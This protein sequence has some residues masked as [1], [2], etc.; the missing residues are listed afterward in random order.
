MSIADSLSRTGYT[1][2]KEG[3]TKIIEYDLPAK[4]KAL[5]KAL[6][7]KP[8]PNVLEKVADVSTVSSKRTADSSESSERSYSDVEMADGQDH[9]SSDAS[10]HADTQLPRAANGMMKT[11]R[12]RGERVIAA[13]EC[14][15]H[16][17]RLFRN[18]RIMCSYLF[19]RHGA[20]APLTKEKL[21]VVTADI[22]F[23]DLI[24]V[25]PTRFRPAAKMGE[26]LFEH[27]QNELLAK[28]ISTS[29]RLRD[30]NY[31]LAAIS[32]KN[33][34]SDDAARRQ[35]FGKVLDALIQVQIDVNSFM[36]SS[37]N[38]AIMKQGKF[39]PAGVKQ[40]LEKK[41]GLFRKNMMA[42]LK[43]DKFPLVLKDSR[44]NV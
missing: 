5:H 39:P 10:E 7:L 18:E 8:R 13:A 2:R 44:E 21:S 9:P 36:D 24:P 14:R 38:P 31:E 6:E 12:G 11:S 32:V 43:G 17:R 37:K 22:F 27:P 34:N 3:H 16:L 33:A 30:L 23:L 35:A 15:E 4:V 28:I 25:V 20:Y 41:D 42:S 19:G 29:Y 1:F 40:V 26:K